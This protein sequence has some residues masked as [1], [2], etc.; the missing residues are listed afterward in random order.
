MKDEYHNVGAALLM[1]V[2]FIMIF[3]PGTI[4]EKIIFAGLGGVSFL[5]GYFSGYLMFRN[6]ENEID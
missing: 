2:I 4:K 1:L 5:F 3:V 6:H